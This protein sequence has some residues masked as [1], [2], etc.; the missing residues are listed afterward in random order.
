MHWRHG[1]I[2]DAT[3]HGDERIESAGGA[4]PGFE[5]GCGGA[6][7][8]RYS[9]VFAAAA[10]DFAGVI[11]RCA[12]LFERWLM[13][14]IDHDQ[15][16]VG[17]GREDGTSRTDHHI[18]CSGS[19]L[20]PLPVAIRVTH[21]AVQHCHRSKAAAKSTDGLRREAD[22]GNQH[23]RLSA[24][25]HHFANGLNVDFRFA[26]SGN[27]VQ[28][29]CFMAAFPEWPEDLIECLQLLEA[30]IE[31]GFMCGGGGIV[32]GDIG[33]NAEGF[34]PAFFAEG[35]EWPWSAA[36]AFAKF[37][38]G[39]W[40]GG[41]LQQRQQSALLNTQ[42]PATGD[43]RDTALCEPH[44]L[45]FPGTA[46][47]THTGRNDAVEYLSPAAEESF[48]NPAG[49]VEHGAVEQWFVVEQAQ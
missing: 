23:D 29:Q 25:G 39:D 10:G 47:V 27:A 38:G 8:E 49:E 19:N 43:G 2:G 22:F 15:S 6:E 26:A 12:V 5:S 46:F 37:C 17:G 7:D 13:L 16:E 20:L 30:Q 18:H 21:V 33:T 24:V 9:Q 44:M 11:T 48:A 28:Q 3:G 4:E 45:H 35:G 31:V 41:L 32:T 1:A 36:G 40:F 34:N 42:T 14:F